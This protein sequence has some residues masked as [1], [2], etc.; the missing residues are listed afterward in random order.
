MSKGVS[1]DCPASRWI[2]ALALLHSW[3][4][5]ILTLM[6]KLMGAAIAGSVAITLTVVASST[7]SNPSGVPNTATSTAAA[8]WLRSRQ[9]NKV[10]GSAFKETSKLAKAT[11]IQ[12][13]KNT[14]EKTNNFIFK[15]KMQQ[16]QQ[17]KKKSRKRMVD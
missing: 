2:Q 10:F 9:T 12:T 14:K 13:D 5:A 8:P 3:R 1:K 7:P 4:S 15:K 11:L 17:Q 6:P 16:Q